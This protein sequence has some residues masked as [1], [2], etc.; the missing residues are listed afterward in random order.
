MKRHMPLLSAGLWALVLAASAGAGQMEDNLEEKL[1]KEFVK[2][3]AWTTDFDAA[4]AKATEG[5]KL[6]FGYFTRSYTP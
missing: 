4:K 2:N 1:Q 3:A 6:I 5:G